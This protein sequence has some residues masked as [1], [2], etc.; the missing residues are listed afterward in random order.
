M[1]GAQPLVFAKEQK[2]KSQGL[3]QVV[4]QWPKTIP[5]RYKPLNRFPANGELAFRRVKTQGN[6]ELDHKTV[7]RVY[8]LFNCVRPMLTERQMNLPLL[9]RFSPICLLNFLASSAVAALA[10]NCF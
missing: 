5:M 6:L 10:C 7:N 4:P 9:L 2:G 1:Y 3:R 8:Y